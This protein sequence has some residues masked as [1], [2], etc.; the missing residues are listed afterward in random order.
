ML[1]ATAKNKIVNSYAL[2]LMDILSDNKDALNI[3][4]SLNDSIKKDVKF[5]NFVVN[6]DVLQQY[7]KILGDLNKSFDKKDE[8][9]SFI[10]QIA[11][12]RYLMFLGDIIEKTKDNMKNV[13]K[14]KKVIVYSCAELC[15]DVKGFI[16][17]VIKE[18]IGDVE[19]EYDIRKN[20]KANTVDFVSDG[21]ICSIDLN[22]ISN[23]FLK[24]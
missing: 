14:N 21:Q 18:K 13:F 2:V 10:N 19:I 3:L 1:N 11:K 4:N 6:P 15:N 5:A 12:R 17:N 8:L 16:N 23:T 24:V 9:C 7:N 20:V 22:K